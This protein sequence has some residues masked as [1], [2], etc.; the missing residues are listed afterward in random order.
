MEG[1]VAVRE[2]NSQPRLRG[3]L[4]PSQTVEVW[5]ALLYPAQARKP[6]YKSTCCGECLL[7]PSGQKGR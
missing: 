5:A 1:S 6:K 2:I 4:G 7:D 3:A